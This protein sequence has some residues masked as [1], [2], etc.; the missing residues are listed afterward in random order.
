LNLYKTKFQYK[1]LILPVLIFCAVLC[2]FWFGFTNAASAN[3]AQ[4]LQV[5]RSAIQKS[6]VNCYAIEGVYPPDVKY[7]E[8][9]YG[10]LIDHNKYIINYDLAGSNIMPSVQILEKGKE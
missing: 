5:M 8:D 3:S 2:L 4:N 1:E 7:L 9:H 6:I 10:I